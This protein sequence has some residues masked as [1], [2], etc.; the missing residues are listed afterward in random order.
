MKINLLPPP[1]PKVRRYF[2]LFWVLVGLLVAWV[3]Q[4]AINFYLDSES[5][6]SKQAMVN[7][8]SATLQ[9][10]Q[11]KLKLLQTKSDK[12]NQSQQLLQIRS[13]LP[14]PMEA[15]QNLYTL[16]PKDGSYT[17]INYSSGTLS[18]SVN[19]SSYY[20]AAA[21]IVG[22]YNDAAFTNVN[23]T[24]ISSSSTGPSTSNQVS[25]SPGSQNVEPSL[26]QV[27]TK[28]EQVSGLKNKTLTPPEKST[29]EALSALARQNNSTL[30]GA[31][32]GNAVTVPF[33]VTI[34]SGFSGTLGK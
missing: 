30:M 17:A 2:I 32:G 15:I 11:A 33:T 4:G 9:Q 5:I 13:E 19:L 31:T 21:F 23:V 27:V 29:L 34:S 22:L 25:V 20:E 12:L 28:I 6:V 7:S 3:I 1:P 24:S 8:T 18:T 26:A 10:L 16:L 14:R